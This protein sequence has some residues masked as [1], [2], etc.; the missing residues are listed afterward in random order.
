MCRRAFGDRCG[1]TTQKKRGDRLILAIDD[2]EPRP[3]NCANRKLNMAVKQA[4]EI[5]VDLDIQP[6]EGQVLGRKKETKPRSNQPIASKIDSQLEELRART[7]EAHARKKAQLNSLVLQNELPLWTDDNRGVPNHFIRSGLFSVRNNE[8]REYVEKVT[9]SSLNNYKIEY[10][11]K[12]LQQD[13]LSVWMALLNMARKKPIGDSVLFTGYEIIKDLGWSMNTRS[14]QRVKTSIE[15]MKV[16]GLEISMNNKDGKKEAAYSGSLIREYLWDSTD[17]KGN[18]KWTVTFEPNVAKL[19][20]NDTT[21]LLE[22]ETRKKI[23]TRATVAQ[24]LHSFYS[25]HKEPIP[26][27]EEKLHELARSGDSISSFRR[28]LKLA[29]QRLVEIGFLSE[30]NVKNGKVY[31]TKKIKQLSIGQDQRKAA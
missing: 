2:K 19:L 3:C 20:M 22:W 7:A 23:G 27:T 17:D 24:W 6:S 30:F 25:S 26:L 14:Y 31:V 5:I 10:T 28:T 16:T 13:D 15:R 12:E 29:L 11:G 18:P 4:F 21:S 8:V 9:I 1:K